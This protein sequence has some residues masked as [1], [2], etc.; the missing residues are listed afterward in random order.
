MKARITNIP[1]DKPAEPVVETKP[2]TE[3]T[4]TEL[5]QEAN[6]ERMSAMSDEAFEAMLKN[7]FGG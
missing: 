7:A 6:Y 5:T 1:V 3:G 4:P 2:K